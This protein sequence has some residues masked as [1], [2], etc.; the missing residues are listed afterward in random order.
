MSNFRKIISMSAVVILGATNLLT[1]LSYANAATWYDALTTG[2]LKNQGLRFVMPDHDVF[3]YAITEA[4][5]YFVEYSGTTKTSWT[6]DNDTFTYDTAWDLSPNL[7]KKTW[8]TFAEWNRQL[9]GGGTGYADWATWVVLNWTATESGVVPIYAQWT[10]NTYNIS[11]NLNKGDGSNDPVHTGSHPTTATYDSGFTV[12]NPS[13]TWYSFSGWTISNMDSEKHTVGWGE[14][15]ATGASGVM[16]TSF[17]NLRSTSGT[18]NFLAIWTKNLHTQYKVE[19]YLE[20]L[21]SGVYPDDPKETDNLSGVTDTSVTPA[22]HTYEWFTANTANTPTSGNIEPDGSKVFRYEYTRNSYNLTLN[23]G[24][25]IASVKWTGTVNTAGASTSSTTTISFKYDEP[26]TLSFT[27]KSWYTGWTWSGYLDDDATFNM[28]AFSTGKTAYANTIPYTITYNTRSGSVSPANPTGYT[29]ESSGITLNN[30]SRI[31]SKFAWWTGWVIGGSQLAGPTMTVTIPNGSTWNRSYTATWTCL[32][33]YHL[34]EAQTQC[35]PNSDTEYHVEHRFQTLTWWSDYDLVSTTTQTW[36][37]EQDTDAKTIDHV[38]FTV[39]TPIDNEPITWDTSTVIKIRYDRNSYIWTIAS[40]TG[41]T[42]AKADGEYADWP[43][44]YDDKVTLTADTLPW[45]TFDHWEVKDASGAT[46]TVTNPTQIDGATFNMPASSVTITPKVTRDTYTITMILHNG[47]GTYP[48]EYTVESLDIPL[49]NPTRDAGS[50]FEGWSWTDITSAPQKPVTIAH[51]SVGNRT[52]EAIWLCRAW[53]HAV[54]DS[55][56]ANNYDV[57]VNHNDGEHNL[58]DEITFT[59][60]EWKTVDEP[61]QSWYDFVWWEITWMSGWVEHYIGTIT[62]TDSGTTYTWEVGSGFM[63]LTTVE[64]GTVTFTALWKART[65]TPYVVYHYVKNVGENKYTLSGNDK[66]EGTTDSTLTL[67]N[68]KKT[69]TGFN[70]SEWYLTGGTTRPASGA[71]ATTTIDKKGRTVI[72]L[73]YDRKLRNVYLSGDVHVD[74]LNGSGQY[75][76]GATVD[77]SATAKTW[78]HFEE[79]KKKRDNTFTTDL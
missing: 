4:N 5:K 11:Y 62:V 40:V 31:H 79:W 46:V 24:R 57:I 33:W 2:D 76:Y 38:W 65:D 78:Y 9:N 16:G 29:V 70:Y 64:S 72:Y 63:N 45:Y 26:V 14:S 34:N 60:D 55:C 61:A 1:P 73:Y 35:M 41:I 74:T 23:A 13:R 44:K 37:T 36:E 18:V 69:F 30:P 22:I 68:L 32:S 6:M 25:W 52:Y 43:Y 50:V 66:L 53:Y 39:Q 54:G 49:P 8:Y 48:E 59:Y 71:V 42:G 75:E 17:E 77:V 67:A 58:P 10:P 7:Y 12:T 21:T 3:L 27:L 47:T 28:P 19:H 56:V 15:Y 51:W 20:T